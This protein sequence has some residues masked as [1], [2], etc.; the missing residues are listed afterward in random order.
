MFTTPP[1]V[2][3]IAGGT[4]SGK[5]ELARF[6][7]AKACGA[8]VIVSQDWYYHDRSMLSASEQLALNFDHPS[9]FDHALL[10]EHLMALKAGRVIRAPSYDYI[11]HR[12]S[13]DGALL[14]PAGIIVLEG[15]LILHEPGLRA[16]LDYSVFVD[17]PADVRL[18]RRLQRDAAS[19]GIPSEETL[20]LYETF[21]RPMHDIFV[22]PSACHASEIW[23]Q[24]Q[25]RDFPARLVTRISEM[26][27]RMESSG[28][29]GR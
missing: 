8:A 21:A 22:Q 24:E 7:A 16:L 1:I 2:V 23:S 13:E 26:R 19:R 25:D 5:T 15:L 3:G 10:R 17:V 14:S 4:G 20:R 28:P 12:R 29:G 6:L 9:A 27:A 11:T 18:T